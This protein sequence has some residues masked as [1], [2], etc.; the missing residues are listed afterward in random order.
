M[1]ILGCRALTMGRNVAKWSSSPDIDQRGLRPAIRNLRSTRFLSSS[2]LPFFF[3]VP[4]LKPNSRKKSTLIIEGA[5]QE[6][7]LVRS[8]RG[9]KPLGVNSTIASDRWSA[10]PQPNAH[11]VRMMHDTCKKQSRASTIPKS[12]FSTLPMLSIVVPFWFTKCIL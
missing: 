8:I 6:P 3:R 1:I 10:A 4:L 2:L 5:T 9:I 12:K 11:A 7:S